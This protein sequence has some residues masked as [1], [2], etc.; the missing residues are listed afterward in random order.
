M[1]IWPTGQ[2]LLRTLS[3]ALQFLIATEG[4]QTAALPGKFG[5]F[6][7]NGATPVPV[8][9]TAVT[10]AS[11]ILIGLL[12]EAG[13]VGALPVVQTKTAGVGFDV[14]GTALDTSTYTYLI[15]G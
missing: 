12:Q 15:L 7:L 13:T 5:S 6:T 1:A 3:G 11:M 10:E 4:P 9:D 14:V 2:V 8:T